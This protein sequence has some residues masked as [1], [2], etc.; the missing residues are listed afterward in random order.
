M[1]SGS[2]WRHIVYREPAPGGDRHGATPGRVVRLV[3]SRVCM[4]VCLGV[5]VGLGISIWVSKLVAPLLYGL[6]PGDAR[7]FGSRTC[8][9]RSARGMGPRAARSAGRSGRQFSRQIIEADV[10]GPLNPAAE[11]PCVRRHLPPPS[12]LLFASASHN[13]RNPLQ[14]ENYLKLRGCQKPSPIM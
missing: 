11:I 2:L 8:D 1:G 12:H 13:P 10:Y 3:L 4:V 5:L 7:V 9:G 6:E 14:A